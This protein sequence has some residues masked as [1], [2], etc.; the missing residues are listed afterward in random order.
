MQG[1]QLWI[2]HRIKVT[3]EIA[4]EACGKC[5]AR[6]GNAS[7]ECFEYNHSASASPHA[8]E[9]LGSG[10]PFAAARE[11]RH[12]ACLYPNPNRRPVR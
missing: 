1:P 10:D 8:E 11:Y 2:H 6:I 7:D 3:P 12:I 4:E 5:G 9:T